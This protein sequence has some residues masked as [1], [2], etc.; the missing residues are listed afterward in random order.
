[1]H[2]APAM[3]E[4]G[5]VPTFSTAWRYVWN[6]AVSR[7][8]APKV[9]YAPVSGRSGETL[10]TSALCQQPTF[11][12]SATLIDSAGPCRYAPT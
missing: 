8:S 9:G 12:S 10:R 5:H 3:S 2:P 6:A 11:R 1:M 4:S 7:H